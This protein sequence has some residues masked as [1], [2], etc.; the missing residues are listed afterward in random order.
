MLHGVG[1]RS[2]VGTR[3]PSTR[4]RCATFPATGSSARRLQQHRPPS[5]NGT[6]CRQPS[7]SGSPGPRPHLPSPSWP[8]P[9]TTFNRTGR[10]ARGA[11]SS[12]GEIDPAPSARRGGPGVGFALVPRLPGSRIEANSA[13]DLRASC[14]ATEE[15][16]L[17]GAVIPALRCRASPR[18]VVT[19][20]WPLRPVPR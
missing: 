6:A 19:K 1:R 15:R 2:Q 3:S 5:T 11:R 4:A 17:M 7:G 20:P 9:T 12:T 10:Q 16:V 18:E 14:L 8:A 13:R